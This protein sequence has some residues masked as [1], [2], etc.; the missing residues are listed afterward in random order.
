MCRLS[1]AFPPALITVIRLSIVGLL[2]LLAAC[3]AP[4][5]IKDQAPKVSYSVNASI[6]LAVIDSRSILKTEQKPP[7]FIGRAHGVFG[8]PTD[9]RVYPWVA[10]KGEKKFTLA[11][12]IEQRI[13]D[14]LQATGANVVR[15]DAGARVDA[16]SARHSAQESNVDR[17]IVITLEEWFVS[18]N[19]NW[20]TAFNFDWGYTVGVYDRAGT[21]LAA[22][23]DSGRDVVD[24]KAS[25]SHRNMITVAY[26]A[27]LQKLIERAEIRST[28]GSARDKN[29]STST[30]PKRA[31]TRST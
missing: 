30:S 8:I 10:L 6:A 24:E 28:L 9:M 5:P 13:T 15:V 25:D 21:E 20:V 7:T 23:K 19:L 22:F 4:I 1:S 31:G 12:E 3:V 16:A 11:Q 2:T 27:R 14:A 18:I 17:I 26:R 29:E